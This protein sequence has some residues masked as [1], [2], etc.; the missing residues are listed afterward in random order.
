MRL[1][2]MYY[3]GNEQAGVVIDDKVVPIVDLNRMFGKKNTWP[4]T[5]LELIQ[6]GKLQALNN[7]LG[8]QDQDVLL[9]SFPH[10]KHLSEIKAAPLYRRPAKIWGIGLNYVEHAADLSEVA[11]NEE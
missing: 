6:E 7:W 11:P 2:T 3:D 1:L 5:V 4:L 8:D 9:Q 10:V